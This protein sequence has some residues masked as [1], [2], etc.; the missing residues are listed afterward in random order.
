MSVEVLMVIAAALLLVM[1][2]G[3]FYLSMRRFGRAKKADHAQLEKLKD[4]LMQ[5]L[6]FQA[7]SEEQKA[8][9]AEA[10]KEMR[11]R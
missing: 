3:L 11:E 4:A 10:L 1:A 9:I 8:K 5:K 2:A 7:L 6:E